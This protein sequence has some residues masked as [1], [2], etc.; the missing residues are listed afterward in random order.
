MAGTTPATTVAANRPAV[1]RG[2]A[3]QTSR[4]TWGSAA[5]VPWTDSLSVRQRV[6]QSFGPDC[7]GPSITGSPVNP[8]FAGTPSGSFG[9]RRPHIQNVDGPPWLGGVIPTRLPYRRFGRRSGS[10]SQL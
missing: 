9:R 6:P 1:T 2:L 8:L 5:V 3:S 7:G 4:S 10:K